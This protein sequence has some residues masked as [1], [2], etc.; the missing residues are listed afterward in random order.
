ML[1][2]PWR[3]LFEWFTTLDY[4]K[5]IALKLTSHTLFYLIIQYVLVKKE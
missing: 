5:A 3:L 1:G 2:V 4:K